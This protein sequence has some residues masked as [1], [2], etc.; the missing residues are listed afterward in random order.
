MTIFSDNPY[1]QYMDPVQQT[2][3]PEPTKPV[4]QKQ[5]V[6]Q[7][8]RK[9]PRKFFLIGGIL[10]LLLIGLFFIISKNNTNSKQK[11]ISQTPTIFPTINPK[12]LTATFTISTSSPESASAY[13]G[14]PF[15]II[16]YIQAKKDISAINTLIEFDPVSLTLEDVKRGKLTENAKEVKKVI[17][18]KNGT[19]TYEITSHPPLNNT[20]VFL[21]LHFKPKQATPNSFISINQKTTV[22]TKENQDATIVIPQRFIF[23][24]LQ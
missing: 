21:I 23:P 2:Q 20:G 4:L 15:P 3:P 8:Q 18:N 22:K 16:I 19:L 14:E 5:P 6:V 13:V 9:I 12:D 17:D 11:S 10:L 24:T 7:N 1:Y